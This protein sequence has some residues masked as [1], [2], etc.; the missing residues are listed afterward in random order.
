MKDGITKYEDM[1][2][3]KFLDYAFGCAYKLRTLIKRQQL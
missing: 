2:F 3:E 1:T